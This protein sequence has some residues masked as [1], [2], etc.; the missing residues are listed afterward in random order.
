MLINYIDDK[1]EKELIPEEIEEIKEF[2]FH[3]YF[4]QV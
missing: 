2:H 4:L 3:V 1:N